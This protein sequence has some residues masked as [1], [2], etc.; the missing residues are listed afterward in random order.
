MSAMSNYLEQQLLQH[1]F[2]TA[3]FTKPTTLAIALASGTITES[4]TGSLGGYEM[5]NAG[6]YAR[7]TLNPL[8]ANWNAVSEVSAS[9]ETANTSAIQFAQATANWGTATDVAI[10][11]SAT[12]GAGNVLLFGKLQTAKTIGTNDQFSFSANQL[13]VYFD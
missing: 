3:S 10:L 13:Q 7:Q 12:Y 8:D 4:M 9:G 1:I 6:G 2:R 5:A 11:D